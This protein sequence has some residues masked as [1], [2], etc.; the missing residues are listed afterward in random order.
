M[1]AAPPV[2]DREARGK[3]QHADDAAAEEREAD[4]LIR[5]KA[6][7]EERARREQEREDRSADR[8]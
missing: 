7:P 2:L 6:E 4:R 5:G 3:G 8:R 1:G